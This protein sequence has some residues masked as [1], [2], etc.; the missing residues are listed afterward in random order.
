MLRQDLRQAII[1]GGV[2]T[3]VGG[4]LFAVGIVMALKNR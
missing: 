4:V 2:F 1:I 3:L